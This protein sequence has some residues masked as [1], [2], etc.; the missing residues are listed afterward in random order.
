MTQSHVGFV[1]AAEK[2][3]RLRAI[4]PAASC[5][6]TRRVIALVNRAAGEYVIAAKKAHFRRPARQKHFEAAGLIGTKENDGGSRAGTN[7]E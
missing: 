5:Q 7:H 4:K 3:T 1:S 2:A 6:H